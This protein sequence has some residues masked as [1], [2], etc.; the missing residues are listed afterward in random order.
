MLNED[1]KQTGAAHAPIATTAAER[2]QRIAELVRPHVATAL[3]SLEDLAINARSAKVRKSAK[4]DLERLRARLAN[5][6]KP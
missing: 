1:G 4:H 6:S 5:G 2:R 3:A